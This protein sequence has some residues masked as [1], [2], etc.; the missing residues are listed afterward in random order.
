MHRKMVWSATVL[1]QVAEAMQSITNTDELF[2]TMV[3]LTP[4]LV[5]INQCAFFSHGS[6]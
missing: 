1:L 4:L 2:S 5:G 3:R 6:E